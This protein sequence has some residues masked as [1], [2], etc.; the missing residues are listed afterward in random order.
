MPAVIAVS[1]SL[2]HPCVQLQCIEI[3]ADAHW[4]K[5]KALKFNRNRSLP[6]MLRTFARFCGGQGGPT[7]GRGMAAPQCRKAEGT[8]LRRRMNP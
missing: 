3:P 2:S 5:V 7:K 1:Q 4:M 6:A 8:D